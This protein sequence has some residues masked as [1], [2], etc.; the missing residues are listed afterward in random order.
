MYLNL[1]NQQYLQ[2]YNKEKVLG[3]KQLN[4]QLFSRKEGCL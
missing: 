1:Q 3:V 2:I 4:L